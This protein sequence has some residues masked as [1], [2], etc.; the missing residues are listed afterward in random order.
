MSTGNQTEAPQVTST[1]FDYVAYDDQ[2]AEM[3]AQVKVRMIA[4]EQV[5]DRLPSGRYKSLALTALEEAYAWVG[6]A[7]RDDQRARAGAD[8]Q[9]R[10]S[11]E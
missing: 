8:L 1:R 6:K 11:N 9:E 3:Q 4:L 7:I 2:A 10:R 5:I